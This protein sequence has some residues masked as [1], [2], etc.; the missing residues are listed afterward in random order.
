MDLEAVKAPP[1]TYRDMSSIP[2][3]GIGNDK[4]KILV[5]AGSASMESDTLVVGIRIFERRPGL[6]APYTWH[7]FYIDGEECI[8]IAESVRHSGI[9]RTIVP[10][11]TLKELL[12]EIHLARRVQSKRRS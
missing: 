2:P 8:R 9:D 6:R 5:K 1:G 7:N 4:T 12:E 10:S 3:E 11:P